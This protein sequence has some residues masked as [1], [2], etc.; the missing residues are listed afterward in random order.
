M[1]RGVQLTTGMTYRNRGGGK[2]Y[3]VSGGDTPI[4]Q[5]VASGWTLVA[6]IVTLYDD[7]TIEWDFSTSG[8]FE[9]SFQPWPKGGIDT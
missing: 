7:G 5:N 9:P 3:C 4:M 8:R 2:F 1:Q 6:H